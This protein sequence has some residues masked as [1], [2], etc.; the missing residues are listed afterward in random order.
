MITQ[1]NLAEVLDSLTEAQISKAMDGPNDY[2][3]LE[4]SCSN[5]CV[6]VDLEDCEWS[7]EVEQEIQ[8]NGN[9]FCYKD[10]FLH[11]VKK[12]DTVNPFLLELV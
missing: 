6:W 12:S 5:A 10:Q 7:E 8:N 2:V 3:S 11:L 1:E 4:V 9:L